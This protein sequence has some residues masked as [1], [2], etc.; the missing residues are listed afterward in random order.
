ME[1]YH[2]AEIYKCPVCKSNTKVI[3]V[4]KDKNVVRCRSCGSNFNINNG[5][6]NDRKRN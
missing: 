3:P 6:N 2:M 4:T 1:K 5:V